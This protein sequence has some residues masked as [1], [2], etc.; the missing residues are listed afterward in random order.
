[1][2]L[3]AQLLV[4]GIREVGVRRGEQPQVCGVGDVEP[5][6]QQ[7]FGDGKDC[8]VRPDRQRERDHRDDREPWALAKQARGENQ[9][10]R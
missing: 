1:M 8:R 2:I 4:D 10:R 5:L 9:I 3:R 7:L 6:E